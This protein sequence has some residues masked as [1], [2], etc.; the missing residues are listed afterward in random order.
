QAWW[1]Q[2]LTAWAHQACA[3]QP[4]RDTGVRAVNNWDF[5]EQDLPDGGGHAVWTCARADT[6]R[7]PGD[8][9]VSFRASGS[10]PAAP[11]R[12][13]A[14]AHATAACSR[15]GQ[16]VVAASGWR[17]PNGHWYALA[18]GSR[19]VT[20]LSVSG[21]I[22]TTKRSRTLAVPAPRDPHITVRARL[23]DG[24]GLDAVGTPGR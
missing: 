13:V 12:T 22:T 16:H 3:L 18:A 1:A 9:T 21:D 7:G 19:A 15:F 6:W 17:S 10:A 14:R 2:A 4:L 11:S 8:V 20:S 24:E 23:A 5:A